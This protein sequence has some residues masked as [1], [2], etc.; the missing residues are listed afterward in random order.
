MNPMMYP[1][2]NPAM[3]N[4]AN[5]NPEMIDPAN[6]NPEMINPIIKLMNNNIQPNNQENDMK[7]NYYIPNDYE[8]EPDYPVT[9]MLID[10]EKG[11]TFKLK[12]FGS[13]SMTIEQ[14]VKKFRTVLCDDNIVIKHYLLNDTIELDPLSKQKLLEFGINDKSIIKA[15]K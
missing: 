7:F 14:L 2:I 5:E 11:K 12:V 1:A 3:I 6:E 8:Y 9:I 15:I 10:T 13:D 4:P